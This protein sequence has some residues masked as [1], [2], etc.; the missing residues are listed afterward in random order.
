VGCL[1]NDSNRQTQRSDKARPTAT[2]IPNPNAE[3]YTLAG[4]ALERRALSGR[5]L[6]GV[7]RRV[8][9]AQIEE[10]LPL[11]LA[12]VL[13]KQPGLQLLEPGGIVQHTHC[14]CACMNRWVHTA[15]RRVV[16]ASSPASSS[17][18]LPSLE[19]LSLEP[20]EADG[21]GAS[22]EGEPG[23]D[24]VYASSSSSSSSS[25]KMPGMWTGASGAAGRCRAGM[26]QCHGSSALGQGACDWCHR[27]CAAG[28]RA[29]WVRGDSCPR[30][31]VCAARRG[32]GCRRA[33]RAGVIRA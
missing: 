23:S 8:A 15:P 11:G 10:G 33:R 14:A 6:L 2:L 16:A 31:S 24:G 18:P 30:S 32:I 13:I 5:T 26:G 19:V 1:C 12:G 4:A 3:Y 20:S 27:H 22:S 17:T 28:G 21:E 25:S 29:P 7:V 9:R